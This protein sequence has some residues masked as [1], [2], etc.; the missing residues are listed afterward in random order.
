MTKRM[1]ECVRVSQTP[2]L[3]RHK[4]ADKYT[5]APGGSSSRRHQD[6]SSTPSLSAQVSSGGQS[7]TETALGHRGGK[8]FFG[9]CLHTRKTWHRRRGKGLATATQ[10]PVLKSPALWSPGVLPSRLA[11]PGYQG[12]EAEGSGNRDQGGWVGSGIQG[13]DLEKHPRVYACLP[14]FIQRSAIGQAL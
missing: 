8:V 9:H 14:S 13:V 4:L 7:A 2:A 3:K 1:P 12:K 6:S 5:I 10:Q 11:S